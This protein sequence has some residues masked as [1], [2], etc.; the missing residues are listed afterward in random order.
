MICLI[1]G[2]L[3]S[4]VESRMRER[5]REAG[6]EVITDLRR[7]ERRLCHDRRGVPWPAPGAP[8]G[9][10]RR[11]VRNPGGRR[12][13]ERRATLVPLDPPAGLPRGAW[14][15]VGAV[16]FVDRLELETQAREDV[17]TARLVTRWQDGDRDAFN[18]LYLRYFDRVYAYLCLALDDRHEAEDATQQVFLQMMEA[19]PRFELRSTPVRAWLFR[20]VRNYALSHASKHRRLCVEDPEVLDRRRDDAGDVAP[21]VLEWLSDA[22]LLV[23][24][25]RLTRQQRQVIM[26]RYTLDLSFAEV[27]ELMGSTPGAVRQLHQRAL[28]FLRARLA[29]LGREHMA[30]PLRVPMRALA[31]RAPAHRY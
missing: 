5:G 15:H 29:S 8:D 1:R 2:G 6:F 19:L 16:S 14:S 31:R 12:V 26:L 13:A 7:R 23:L 28:E 18:A 27:A 24:I 20:I 3:P 21:H 9:D 10:D 30:P 25:G 22:D 17:D 4:R 11:R